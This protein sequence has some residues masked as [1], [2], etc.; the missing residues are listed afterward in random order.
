MPIVLVI[1]YVWP[2]PNSSAAGQR[3]LQILEYF[4]LNNYQVIFTTTAAPSEKMVNLEELGISSEKIELNNSSFDD[5]ISQLQPEIVLFDRFMMEEQFGWRVDKFSPDSIKILDTEDLHFLRNYRADTKLDKASIKNSE[6]AK[7]EIASIYR[8]DLTLIISEEEMNLLTTE[9]DIPNYLLLYLPFLINPILETDLLPTFEQRQNFISI[10][11]FKH[12]PNVDAV[13]YLKKEIW[14]LIRIGLPEAELHIYGAYPTQNILQFHNPKEKFLIKGWAENA[15][16]IVK[17][18]R[19]SLA[20]LRFGAGL[21]GK[22]AEAMKCG[23]PNVTT[24]IGTEGMSGT[25]PWSGYVAE[26]ALEFAK[27]AVSL[28]LD[29]ETW[30]VFQQNGFALIENRF[31]KATFHAVLTNRLADLASNLQE[32]RNSNFIGSMLSY[33]SMKSTQHLS[34]YIQIKNELERLKEDDAKQDLSSI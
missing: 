18:A 9:F 7:R 29:K 24:L 23:T 13:N 14:P 26:S 25:H 30:L 4:T 12:K 10:G 17:N 19:V 34:K 31:N 21:K 11:N 3:M 22:L 15:E 20:A 6:L 2:E 28:Y 8:C 27:A 33:H 5:Y 1:G 32:Y 16:N